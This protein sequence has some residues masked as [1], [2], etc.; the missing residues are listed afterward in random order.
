[1]KEKP[2]PIYLNK[3]EAELFKWMMK[4]Y[5]IFN[6]ARQIRLGSTTLHS[7]KK[8]NIKAEFRIWSE[9]KS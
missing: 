2:T 7:D 4:Y 1:M 6:Y 9:S 8:G 5:K 3:E